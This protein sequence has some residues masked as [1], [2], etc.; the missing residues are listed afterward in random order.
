MWEKCASPSLRCELDCY[1]DFSCMSIADLIQTQ[2]SMGTPSCLHLPW[3]RVT[4][5]FWHCPSQVSAI[6][7]ELMKTEYDAVRIIFN[8]FS[9][10]ISFKPTVATVLSPDALEKEV[11]AGGKLDV[12]EMEGPDRGELL[13]DLAEFQ[14]AAV[15]S[16]TALEYD[17]IVLEC[18]CLNCKFPGTCACICSCIVLGVHVAA[19]SKSWRLCAD[20]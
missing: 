5:G 3:N 16:H 15:R 6:A 17:F 9:S 1:S 19:A 11:E 7:E 14:L 2:G 12:Y 20:A 13:Q 4:P 10:A 8:R 18:T